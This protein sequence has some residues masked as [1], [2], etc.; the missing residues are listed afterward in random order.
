M[1]FTDL[2][3]WG[4]PKDKSAYLGWGSERTWFTYNT[5]LKLIN[6]FLPRKEG[7]Q[8]V[9]DLKR[10]DCLWFNL[11]YPD[12]TS[13]V[14]KMIMHNQWKSTEFG[15]WIK[16]VKEPMKVL[17]ILRQSDPGTSVCGGD[18]QLEWWAS[19]LALPGNSILMQMKETMPG[20]ATKVS[21]TQCVSRWNESWFLKQTVLPVPIR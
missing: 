21:P 16:T 10:L 7:A 1:D 15:A 12:C 19:T 18:A 8:G 11:L 20:Q 4:C 14:W 5:Y 9:C 6:V 13:V 3:S 17:F 2:H